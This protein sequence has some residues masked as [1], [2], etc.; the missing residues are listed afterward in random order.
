MADRDVIQALRAIKA[1]ALQHH[2]DE[3]PSA[4]LHAL[5]V[6]IPAE[7][8]S[9][10]AALDAAD[11]RPA[12]SDIWQHDETGRIV[13]LPAGSPSPGKRYFRV[14][15]MGG[16]VSVVGEGD[17]ARVV[18]T[19][20]ARPT[21]PAPADDASGAEA[22]VGAYIAWRDRLG[23]LATDRDETGFAA[24][25]R[26]AIRALPLPAAD[27]EVAR[28]K[29][30]LRYTAIECGMAVVNEAPYAWIERES[31]SDD[32]NG[33]PYDGWRVHIDKQP[34]PE[35]WEDFDQAYDE[36]VVLLAA[37]RAKGGGRA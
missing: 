3:P 26:A 23:S 18:F 22:W 13:E 16:R 7:C 37:E 6:E 34:R 12:D 11:A 15:G 33:E 14:R 27:D 24:G 29:D 35:V 20:D 8:D 32:G 19:P 30:A 2:G 5:L 1:L 25:Y 28:L 17:E 4:L 31:G 21:P 10:I 36:A 9:A